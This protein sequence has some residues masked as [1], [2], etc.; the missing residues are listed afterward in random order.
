MSDPFRALDQGTSS[1]HPRP[2]RESREGASREQD[3]WKKAGVGVK[4]YSTLHPSG[5]SSCVTW[6]KSQILTVAF[7]DLQEL[8]PLCKMNQ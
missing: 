8:L 6:I 4:C 2:F 5:R 1:C 3:R 7:E